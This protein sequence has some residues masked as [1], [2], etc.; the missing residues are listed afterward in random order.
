MK[1]AA[2]IQVFRQAHWMLLGLVPCLALSFWVAGLKFGKRVEDTY[3]D[4]H[5]MAALKTFE[6]A[7]VPAAP[8]E[9][10]AAVTAE[11]LRDRFP[12]AGPARLAALAGQ[13]E[14]LE[15]KLRQL[16][17][18]AGK[19]LRFDPDLWRP[20]EA[21][22]GD[23][24]AAADWLVQ[25]RRLEEAMDWPGLRR[26]RFD[27]V[28]RVPETV[29]LQDNPWR[30]ADG[31]VFLG[32]TAPGPEGRLYYLAEQRSHTETCP[33]MAP[34]EFGRTRT[35]GIARPKGDK[36]RRY[37]LAEGDPAWA[38]PEDLGTI[39]A[40]LN[41]IR[42]PEGV[43]YGDYTEVPASPAEGDTGTDRPRPH[44]S[45]RLK[46]KKRDVDVGFNVYLTLDTRTQA[47]VQQWTRCYAGDHRACGIAGLD[48]N[49]RAMK[50]AAEMYEGAAVRMAA[51]ALIDVATGRIEALGSAHTDCY[52]QDHDG[53]GHGS[54]CPDAPFRPRYD[55]DR[56][57]NHAV[58]VDAL[59]ASTV[60]PV[61]ALGFMMDNPAYRSGQPLKQLQD[62]L[63]HSRSAN[64]LDR[65]FCGRDLVGQR[66]WQWRDCQRPRRI[67]EAAMKLGWNLECTA[68]RY[69]PD[70]A[71]LDLLF[72]RPAGRR[73]VEGVR[74]QPMGLALLYGRLL[75]EP[76]RN[77][78]AV[79]ADEWSEAGPD[80]PQ[81][82]ARLMPEFRFDES[83]A[84]ACAAGQ[85][86]DNS[87]GRWRRCKGLGGLVA[88][89]GWGQG[90]ARATPVGVAGMAAR[91]AAAANGAGEQRFPHLVDHIGDA[92]GRPFRLPLERLAGPVP[93]EVEPE[94]ARL[95]LRGL[96]SHTRGGTADD[97]CAN[98]FGAKVCEG[99]DWIA[100][101]TGTPPFRF[102]Q[103]PLPRIRKICAPEKA[104][105]R[106]ET[107]NVIPYKWYVA[108][109]KTR[110][111]A[112]MPYDKAIAVLSERNWRR[113][114]GL[115]QAPGDNET[116]L[117]AELAFRIIKVLREDPRQAE[118]AGKL[119][120]KAQP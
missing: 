69:S 116:N 80:E 7:I 83:F 62:D 63:K 76:Y 82:G 101:K 30:G 107:C 56:L 11:S 97:A 106:G 73:V 85:S 37:A 110:S 48:R 13:L 50:L 66:P 113:K 14:I 67:Q 90:E 109:F 60:K 33:A 35:A 77:T 71:Q 119:S 19:P 61:M 118:P 74:R 26:D 112:G 40:D 16:G 9:A 10:Q 68:D 6:S 87:S 18:S 59:P 5:R 4:P 120:E 49:D 27:T 25:G 8:G 93:I 12:C 17:R 58:Y 45:N 52:E 51:V 24:L 88:N 32:P 91:L 22:C 75:V 29:F 1:P 64:F 114:S 23:V 103:T 111:G 42:R 78:A 108:A 98:V 31:C 28:M 53:P 115:V 70:C 36:D 95:V 38:I 55:S 81:G 47:L 104:R 105:A 34:P 102:D 57:L 117:S 92:E 43:T 46:V 3:R 41:R 72:G 99:I 86:G 2:R 94:L 100:G 79:P 20:A 84:K 21:D 89:E 15:A 96:A 65:M 54:E 39:L 44:G